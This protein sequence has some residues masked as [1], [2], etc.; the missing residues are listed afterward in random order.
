VFTAWL[1]RAIEADAIPAPA[2]GRN[3][4]GF[5]SLRW[6]AGDREVLLVAYPA[7]ARALVSGPGQSHG[8]TIRRNCA[9]GVRRLVAWLDPGANRAPAAPSEGAAREPD[10]YL[11]YVD[12]L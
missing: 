1:L 4:A 6:A 5:P 7:F 10:G 2:V 11:F 8:I 9:D 12:F 3:A